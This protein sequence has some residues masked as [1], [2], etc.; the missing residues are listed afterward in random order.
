MESNKQKTFIE[1]E[2]LGE[3]TNINI[4]GT[5]LKLAQSVAA[6][7]LE[8]QNTQDILLIGMAAAIL[9]EPDILVKLIK[10]YAGARVENV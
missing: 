8:D 6:A 1:I 10:A 9:K 3:S 4:S 2:N 7:I 5:K